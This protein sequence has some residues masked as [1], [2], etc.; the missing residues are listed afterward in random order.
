MANAEF[1]VK[2]LVDA[3]QQATDETKRAVAAFVKTAAESTASEVG[4][5]YPIGPTENLSRMVYAIPGRY[6][7][8]TSLGIALTYLTRATA[9]HVHILEYGTRPREVHTRNGRALKKA[10]N[11]GRGPAIGPIFVPTAKAARANML[12]RAEVWLQQDRE[13]V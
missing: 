7:Q 11:R 10:A 4:S 9:P 8:I 5:R 1:T 3:M 13:L 6:G 2:R 12:A